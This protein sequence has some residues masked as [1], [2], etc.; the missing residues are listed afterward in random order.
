MVANLPGWLR[1]SNDHH[2]MEF[3]VS[4]PRC[5]TLETLWFWRDRLEPTKRFSQKSDG[6]VYHDCGSQLPCRLFLI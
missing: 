2:F 5:L 1:G 6:K 3:I 4:C